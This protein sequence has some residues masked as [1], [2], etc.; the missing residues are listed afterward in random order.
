[1]RTS[2]KVYY[3]SPQKIKHGTK[4]Y[5]GLM[6]LS[7]AL[8]KVARVNL[9]VRVGHGVKSRKEIEVLQLRPLGNEEGNRSKRG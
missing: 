2:V 4:A 7:S 5:H 1:V 3:V 8:V 6:R 9:S